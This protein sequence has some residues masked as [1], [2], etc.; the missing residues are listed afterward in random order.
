MQ[1]LRDDWSSRKPRSPTEKARASTRADRT[2]GRTCLL[3][4]P[5]DWFWVSVGCLASFLTTA[6][7]NILG[8]QQ[9]PLGTDGFPS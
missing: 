1:E 9:C 7:L 4:N 3:Q 5:T 6:F 2:V 8:G